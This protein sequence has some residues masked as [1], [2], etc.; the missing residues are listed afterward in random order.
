MMLC[1]IPLNCSAYGRD[2][3]KVD[4]TA[5][6]LWFQVFYTTFSG[7]YVGTVQTAALVYPP[8]IVFFGAIGAAVVIVVTV[9]LSLGPSASSHQAHLVTLGP[10]VY[11]GLWL[12]TSTYYTFIPM[13]GWCKAGAPAVVEKAEDARDAE[14]DTLDGESAPE[15]PSRTGQQERKG[16]VAV[17]SGGRSLLRADVHKMAVAERGK[18]SDGLSLGE[19]ETGGD[20]L[21]AASEPLNELK[22]T[23]RVKKPFKI[24]WLGAWNLKPEVRATKERNAPRHFGPVIVGVLLCYAVYTACLN[25]TIAHEEKKG[26]PGSFIGSTFVIGMVLYLTAE[27]SKYITFQ[28]VN[29]RVDSVSAGV[30]FDFVNIYFIDL[31]YFSFYR[32][33]MEGVDNPGSYVVLLMTR[34]VSELML[35]VV[36]FHPKVYRL[37]FAFYKMIRWVPPQEQVETYRKKKLGVSA[38]MFGIRAL[39][40][41]S[42]VA[43]ALFTSLSIKYAPSYS[44][45]AFKS[46][47]KPSSWGYLAGGIVVDSLVTGGIAYVYAKSYELNI[48]RL[49]AEVLTENRAFAAMLMIIAFHVCGDMMIRLFTPS[50]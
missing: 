3:C 45:Q 13:G 38:V 6:V 47:I 29:G 43:I 28:I 10:Y 19:V 5:Y 15:L 16:G 9:L 25:G 22:F 18:A 48:L 35:R 11:F 8:K 41:I 31:I 33:V 4:F 40:D 23:D 26:N 24:V 49:W 21:E 7:I 17:R 39:G 46:L 2:D 30:R 12:L 34:I 1:I 36:R 32:V 42:A 50:F 27:V 37:E 44:D 20:G 14:S